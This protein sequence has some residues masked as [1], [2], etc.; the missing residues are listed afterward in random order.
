MRP[1]ARRRNIGIKHH[2]LRRSARVFL[3]TLPGPGAGAASPARFQNGFGTA[4][5]LAS[6]PVLM[7]RLPLL[8]AGAAREFFFS[9]PRLHSRGPARVA[10][11]ATSRPSPSVLPRL[12][13]TNL[14]R[15]F[16][17]PPWPPSFASPSRPGSNLF[18]P[19]QAATERAL[20]HLGARTSV[21]FVL[22][23]S[24]LARSHGC[25]PSVVRSM[26]RK[27]GLYVWPTLKFP[28]F[29]LL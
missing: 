10:R 8:Y 11:R 22:F 28:V 24:G 27:A 9:S 23:C 2:F 18:P 26:C 4:L 5:T 12:L 15:V 3:W 1:D 14:S 6:S 7:P 21:L 29:S 20:C 13:P 16:C 17:S 25:T 19:F